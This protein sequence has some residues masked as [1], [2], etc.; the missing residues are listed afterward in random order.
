MEWERRPPGMG[1]QTGSGMGNADQ[2]GRIEP[3]LEDEGTLDLRLTAEDRAMPSGKPRGRLKPSGNGGPG[4]AQKR[5]HTTDKRTGKAGRNRRAGRRRRG[6]GNGGGFG[7]FLSRS[8]YWTFVLGVWAFLAVAGVVAYY[9]YHMPGLAELQVPERPASVK[10]LATDGTSLGQRGQMHGHAVA[11]RNL[12]PYVVQAVIATEDSRF[13]SHFGIDVVGVTRAMMTNISAGRLVQG[14]ST[15][16]QQLAK[17]LFLEPKRTLDRKIQEAILAVWLEQR[18]TKDEILEMYLN[19]VYFGAGSYGIE[20]ASQRYFGKSAREVMLSEAAI[21]AGLLKAP[22]RFAP[23]RHPER[24]EA[25][26]RVVLQRMVEEGFITESEG[27]LALARPAEVASHGA[28]SADYVADWVADRVEQILGNLTEDVFVETTIDL[29]LQEAA[30]AAVVDVIREKGGE[31][32]ASQAALLAIDGIGA[33]RAMVGGVSYQASQYNRATVAKRQPGSAFKPFVYLAALERGYTPEHMFMDE[34]VDFNG[35]APKNYDGNYHGPMRLV[36]ALARST[37]TIAAQLAV[38][39]GPQFVAATAKRLGIKSDLHTN[40]SIALG[41]AEVSLFEMT[42][43][44]VPFANGGYGVDTHVIKRIRTA[45][46]EVLFER[47]PRNFGVVVSPDHLGAMNHMLRQAVEIGTGRYAQLSGWQVAGKTG[48]TQDF[49]DG[50][51]I[52][53]TANLTAGVWVGNDDSAPM[54]KVTGGNLPV[55]IWQAFMSEAHQGVMVADLPGNYVAPV[56]ANPAG[57]HQGGWQG[58]SWFG[59][60]AANEFPGSDGERRPNTGDGVGGF[61][62]RIFG[63]G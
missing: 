14:G 41:T 29:V 8:V 11:V 56:A 17:N 10:V 25:R 47:Q 51:F 20:A 6:D 57:S 5:R 60:R 23:T 55:E 2:Y 48:T 62:R 18:F 50:W 36:D 63:G 54:I 4:Y 22:S 7:R 59:G 44:Y 19:R 37:N 1:P 49:R 26:S 39:T 42:T 12:P 28:G 53:Y 3:R 32:N 9:V 34:P 13:Y 52:G 40:A 33:V 35:W 21:L 31:R 46:G 27:K 15:I 16:T 45:S 61:F 30:E 38:Q 58:R 43:A 24:A